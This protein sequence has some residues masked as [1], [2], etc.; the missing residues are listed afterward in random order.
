MLGKFTWWAQSPAKLVTALAFTLSLPLA[1]ASELRNGNGVA[2]SPLFPTG[3]LVAT[4]LGRITTPTFSVTYQEQVLS[5]PGNSW[6]PG[7]LNFLYMLTNGGLDINEHYS[8]SSF[9]GFLVDMRTN[10]FGVHDPATADRS[11]TGTVIG[12]NFTLSDEV[13]PGETTPWL[14]RA[15]PSSEFILY[16]IGLVC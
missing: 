1:N 13:T 7:C 2:P 10:P 5:N 14:V 8:M 4:G 12:F 15:C 16:P 3:A 9:T 11:Q 6:C